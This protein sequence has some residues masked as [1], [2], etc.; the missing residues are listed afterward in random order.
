[1]SPQGLGKAESLIP[2][3]A[4][5]RSNEVDIAVLKRDVNE[6]RERLRYPA[7]PD[8]TDR[9]EPVVPDDDDETV[10][11]VCPEPEPCPKCPSPKSTP[12]CSP[13]PSAEP[14]P[15]PSPEL[16]P[17][18]SP[19]PSAEPGLAGGPGPGLVGDPKESDGE[20]GIG[21][22]YGVDESLEW[23]KSDRIRRILKPGGLFDRTKESADELHVVC[24][25][26]NA[27]IDNMQGVKQGLVASYTTGSHPF[28]ASSNVRFQ[29]ERKTSSF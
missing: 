10:P 22:S 18:S 11:K 25:Y 23:L 26:L 13:K 2:R 9:K 1:M 21:T 8:Q 17:E 16:S 5:I 12:E 19:E 28:N 7:E 29:D 3:G 14:S 24:N 27:R 20:S 6:L 15:E 4:R